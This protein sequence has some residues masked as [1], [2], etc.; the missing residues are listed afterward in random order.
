M[1][2]RFAFSRPQVHVLADRLLQEAGERDVAIRAVLR[3]QALLGLGNGALFAMAQENGQHVLLLRRYYFS[4]LSMPP[5]PP[6]PPLLTRLTTARTSHRP[7]NSSR[8]SSERAASSTRRPT[9]A[10]PRP[11]RCTASSKAARRPRPT[12]SCCAKRTCSVD[13]RRTRW[14]ATPRLRRRRRRRCRRACART[15]RSSTLR[16]RR[17][18]P[19]RSRRR[20]RR[21]RRARRSACR[22]RA[23]T[24][25]RPRCS[26]RRR[27]DTRPSAGRR[28]LKACCECCTRARPSLARGRRRSASRSTRSIS[29]SDERVPRSARGGR[30]TG[31]GGERGRG[32]VPRPVPKSETRNARTFRRLKQYVYIINIYIISHNLQRRQLTKSSCISCFGF[33]DRP[34]GPLPLSPPPHRLLTAVSRSWVSHTLRG[35]RLRSAERVSE[36]VSERCTC[37]NTSTFP[38]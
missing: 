18:S 8:P 30:G 29:E 20:P 5:L 12:R 31:G 27:A 38:V 10:R 28:A 4:L 2:R 7:Q 23:C 25:R 35:V 6:P 37:P 13:L 16:F 26:R 15:R 36:R 3:G 24:A 1:E 19:R 21:V 33:R 9:L 32:G 22:T 34:G 17:A 14:S 11:R